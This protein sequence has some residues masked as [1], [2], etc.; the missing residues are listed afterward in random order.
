MTPLAG[1]R[2]K[3]RALPINIASLQDISYGADST[4]SDFF[5]GKETTL[6]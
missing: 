3:K 6:C 2:S 5:G 1:L 4:N